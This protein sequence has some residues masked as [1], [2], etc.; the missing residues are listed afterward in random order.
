[1]VLVQASAVHQ[2]QKITSEM[3]ASIVQATT[4]PKH[5]LSDDQKAL[6]VSTAIFPDDEDASFYLRI[7]LSPNSCHNLE[8]EIQQSLLLSLRDRGYPQIVQF[9]ERL[10]ASTK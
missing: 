3:A 2:R 4:K 10:L 6:M 8:D 5:P 9:I 1:M 7:A